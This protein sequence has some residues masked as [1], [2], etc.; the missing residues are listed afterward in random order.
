MRQPVAPPQEFVMP[1]IKGAR[2]I[3]PIYLD[4]PS[5]MKSQESM[6]SPTAIFTILWINDTA[7]FI[8]LLYYLYGWMKNCQKG[9]GKRNVLFIKKLVT[10]FFLFAILDLNIR[11]Q[12]ERKLLQDIN[13]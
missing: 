9:F 3:I 10:F 12:N 5:P 11:G 6:A 8:F 7:E 13:D 2:P 1:E 4:S